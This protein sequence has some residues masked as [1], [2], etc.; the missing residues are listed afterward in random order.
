MLGALLMLGL[1]PGPLLFTQ[2]PQFVWGLIAS[3]YIGNVMLLVLNLPLVGMWVK[4]LDVPLYLLTLFIV[5]FS[6]LGVYTMNN[7]AQD[8]L[9]MVVFGVIGYLMK[10][11]D[12]PAAPVILGIVLGKLMEEKMRQSLVISDGSLMIF[13]SRPISLFLLILAVIAITNPYWKQIG[14]GFRKLLGGSPAA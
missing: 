14:R 9:L 12:I 3:M 7:S 4:L 6:F 8:L 1:Q 13:I 5:M 2:Q 10:R 11:L